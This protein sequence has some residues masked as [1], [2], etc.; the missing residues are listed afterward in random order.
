M[1]APGRPGARALGAWAPGTR[2]PGR[3]GV[4]KGST[5][6]LTRNTPS[7]RPKVGYGVAIC[8]ESH[9]FKTPTSKRAELLEDP[10][11]HPNGA[12]AEPAARAGQRS[13]A[14][15]KGERG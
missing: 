6:Q 13:D 15:K 4:E 11:R 5:V 7:S 8:D 12:P 9:S 14:T 1:R 2:A 10:P 3:P